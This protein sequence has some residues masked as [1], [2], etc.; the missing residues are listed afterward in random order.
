MRLKSKTVPRCNSIFVDVTL[1]KSVAGCHD[2]TVFI[3][4]RRVL[5]G[6]SRTEKFC[7]NARCWIVYSEEVF[8]RHLVSPGLLHG[9][10]PPQIVRIILH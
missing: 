9:N 4:D 5:R 6:H 3:L 7:T 8:I 10:S 1:D 2:T